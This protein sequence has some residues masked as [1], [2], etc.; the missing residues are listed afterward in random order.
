MYQAPRGTQDILPED[1]PY[2]EFVRSTAADVCRRYGFERLDIPLFEETSL[3]VRGVGEGTDIVDKEMYSFEDKGG[4]ELTLRPEFT[5]GVIRAYIE[6]G[7]HTRPQPVKV[8]SIG[9][10]FRY[11][12]PQAGRFRQFHQ[13]NVESIGEQDPLVDAEIIS[14]MWSFLEALGFGGLLLQLNNIGCPACRPAYM[15]ALQDYYRSHVDELC[16]DCRRRLERNPLRL[17]DC[18]ATGCQPLIAGA[19]RSTNHLCADCSQHFARLRAYLDELG[20]PYELNHRLVRG[21]DYYTKTVFEVWA[22]GI[23][24][25]NAVCGGGRYDGLTEELGGKPT[26]GIGVACGLERLVSL[27]RQQERPVPPPQRPLAYFAYRGDSARLAAL[28]AV[29]ALRSLGAAAEI[30]FGDRSLKAQMKAANRSGAGWAAILGDDELARGV[31]VV[32]SMRDSEQVEVPLGELAS[33][34]AARVTQP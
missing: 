19:P 22:E 32:R 7:M 23:G 16:E 2:W 17:L 1:Q 14:V 20:R 29:E 21:L 4:T 3:F 5:A 10:A 18:K 24:A 11:E 33:W 9:P 30:A 34:L 27:L 28:R 26:P 25:Q 6:H 8:F 12:R 31:A 15:Q 13:L